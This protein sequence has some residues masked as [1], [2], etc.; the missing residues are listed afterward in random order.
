MAMRV[1]KVAKETVTNFI[2]DDALSQ[3]AAIAYYTIFSIAPVLVIAIAVAGLVFGQEAVQGAIVGQLSGLMGHQS[4]DAIQGMIKSAA[5]R[6]SG[7]IATVLGLGT[8]LVT[9]SGVFGQMQS[10]LNLIW[11]AE[12]KA[13]V[14]RL[15]K[16]RIAS[17]GLVVALGFL[18]MVS[19]VVS[20]AISTLDNVLNG[21]LPG[22]HIL[23]QIGN[24]GIS[25]VLIAVL[26]AA[27]Y[28]VLP[29]KQ[30]AWRDVAVGALA[31]SLLFTIG[32]SLIGFYI[33]HTDIASSYGGAGAFVI[34]LLWIYYSSQIFLLGA[35]F[36]HVYA[37]TH[38][39]HSVEGS[40][41][42]APPARA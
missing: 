7:V 40:A 26:F 42:D 14:T 4:A 13:G 22:A 25:L 11:K 35:E 18:L 39:S 28:K 1:W 33:G 3:G 38:G 32:K 12:P 29:D 15:V 6:K 5:N 27:I 20:A 24:F 36:T 2:A 9:A 21:F 31:T 30:I 41:R 8:L 19:L 16:A 23:M 34:V 37:E 10:A 17:L